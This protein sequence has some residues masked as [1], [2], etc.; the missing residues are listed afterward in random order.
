MFSVI[1]DIKKQV[2][3]F[4]PGKDIYS[5]YNCIPLL[6]EKDMVFHSSNVMTMKDIEPLLEQN[7]V[8][9]LGLVGYE[10]TYNELSKINDITSIKYFALLEKNEKGIL[11]A[12]ENKYA[13]FSERLVNKESEKVLLNKINFVFNNDFIDNNLKREAY[14]GSSSLKMPLRYIM[15]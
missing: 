11:E 9:G 10:A 13:M 12:W 2:G 8:G 15:R 7:V 3:V 4:G 5:Y 14:N 6:S 1:C